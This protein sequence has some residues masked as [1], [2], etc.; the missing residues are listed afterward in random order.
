MKT[1][2]LVV[3]FFLFVL[4]AHSVWAVTRFSFEEAAASSLKDSDLLSSW[5][6]FSKNLGFFPRIVSDDL[7]I[8]SGDFFPGW[9]IQTQLLTLLPEGQLEL[10]LNSFYPH[11]PSNSYFDRGVETQAILKL[12][13]FFPLRIEA[14]AGPSYQVQTLSRQLVPRSGKS[15]GLFTSFEDFNIFGRYQ[16]HYRSLGGNLINRLRGGVS[17]KLP[18]LD[19]FNFEVAGESL[20]KQVN[21]LHGNLLENFRWQ[22]KTVVEPVEKVELRGVFSGQKLNREQML[23]G[24]GVKLKNYFDTGTDFS[25]EGYRVGNSYYQEFKTLPTETVFENLD[26]L[27]NSGQAGVGAGVKQR[28]FSCALSLLG[29]VNLNFDQ[30]FKK[31]TCELGV[32]YDINPEVHLAAGWR[33]HY[34]LSERER[35]LEY[36]AAGMNLE[37]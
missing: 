32:A 5:K 26:Y 2:K 20:L 15:L 10:G 7:K 36:L 18:L 24:A 13:D 8:N 30:N 3:V 4:L 37:F 35:V 17:Y 19:N 28:I 11:A 25:V 16:V 1:Y 14:T 22:V 21:F 6:N 12:K 31:A 27:V 33:S 29:K 9:G 23:V 34:N